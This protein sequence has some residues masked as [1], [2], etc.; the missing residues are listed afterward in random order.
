[1]QRQFTHLRERLAA[2]FQ[3]KNYKSLFF[4]G[5]L[6]GLLPCGLLYLAL[7]G[8]V[9]TGSSLKSS[10]FM[11]AFGLGTLPLM[12]T[13]SF[14]G[15]LAGNATRKKLKLIYPYMMAFVACLLIMRGAGFH[16]PFLE[17]AG[18]KTGAIDCNEP[19]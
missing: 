14:F 4:I 18:I 9:S 2:L 8:A 13:L 19:F 17:S 3:Q 7:A 12:W 10:F 5:I 1:M 11:A 15:S 16:I 6:N